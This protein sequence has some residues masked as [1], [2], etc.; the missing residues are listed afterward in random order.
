MAGAAPR[1]VIAGAGLAGSLLAV[2]CARRGLAPLVV[3]ARPDP[4]R[5][6][7][8]GGRSINLALAARG[9]AALEYAGLRER[10]EP[11]LVPM[12]GRRV[13]EPGDATGRFMRYGQRPDEVI[14]SVSRD[15]LNR[16]LLDAAEATPG[17]KLR[18]ATRCTDVAPADGTL[19]LEDGD[20]HRHAQ[21]ATLVIACD[22][23]GS[24]VRQALQARGLLD[25]REDWL[26]HDYKELALPPAP[27]GSHQ[28]DPNAL[29]IWPR[30][31]FMLIALPNTDATFTCTLFLARDAA[32]GFAQLRDAASVDAFFAREFADV[33]ARIP[34][35]AAQFLANPQGRLGTL[36][37]RPWVHGGRVALLGDAAHAIVPFHGQ[38]MNCAFEDCVALDRLLG[39]HGDDTA[40]AL[41]AYEAE[42]KPNADAIARM[43]LENYVE[44]RD[45]VRDPRFELQRELAFELERRHPARFVPRYSMVMFRPDIPYVTALERG[46]RQQELLAEFTGD[47]QTLADVDHA[48]AD[49][50]VR[51]RL[52]P[53]AKPPPAP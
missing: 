51:A 31:G 53:L 45:G 47:A 8:G 18:F 7:P 21:P 43:A 41:A 16:A 19:I 20:G 35:L 34:D 40:A 22:G 36:Y 3:E 6:Q 10:I 2:L 1:L 11:L 23:A 15:A 9:L 42:R 5:A 14:H 13:H 30:G 25:A 50:A 48:R 39:A 29:H 26:A 28:L 52:A 24:A 38:G 4:R 27:D 46:E 33:H 44:M 49:A 32:P 12:S 37:C 17:V